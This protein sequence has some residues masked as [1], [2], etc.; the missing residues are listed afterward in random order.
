ML[1]KIESRVIVPMLTTTQAIWIP[2]FMPT[3]GEREKTVSIAGS[4][5]KGRKLEGLTVVFSVEANRQYRPREIVERHRVTVSEDLWEQLERIGRDRDVY[6]GVGQ[7]RQLGFPWLTEV[8]HGYSPTIQRMRKNGINLIVSRMIIAS[9]V[10]PLWGSKCQC[11][12]L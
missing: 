2:K 3:E 5:E 12:T 11:L 6:C 8:F 10:R 7:V 9:S 4:L 1:T